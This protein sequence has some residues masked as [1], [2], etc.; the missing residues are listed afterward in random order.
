MVQQDHAEFHCAM[1]VILLYAPTKQQ[2]SA[3]AASSPL[4]P[5]AILIE[6]YTRTNT[7]I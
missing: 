1:V 7:I 3:V 5:P 2:H 6:G 4:S